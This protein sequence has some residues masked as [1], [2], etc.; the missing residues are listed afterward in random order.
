MPKYIKGFILGVIITFPL[1]IN[2]GKDVPLLS[3]PFAAKPDIAAK[4]IERTGSLLDDTKAA[5]HEATKPDPNSPDEEM[6]EPK[7]T[8]G[9]RQL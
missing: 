6:I 7:P 3:N 5:I 2:F 1:G 9:P 4:V 8:A